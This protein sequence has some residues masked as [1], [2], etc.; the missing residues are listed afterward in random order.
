MLQQF[1]V[2]DEDV[3]PLAE[4]VLEVLEKV[5]ILCQNDEL[6]GL[7]DRAGATV[8]FAAQRAR[9]P[10]QMVA[11]Y[12]AQFRSERHDE[13]PCEPFRAPGKPVLGPQAAQFY[14]DPVTGERRSGNT[15]DF[16]ECLKLGE[17]LHGDQ[18]VGHALFST[19][20]PPLLEPLNAAI[21]LA[22]HATRINWVY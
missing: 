21:L 1:L 9:F 2:R 17:M 20:V 16:I 11:E 18:G 5:G 22:E 10:K 8:D 4:A 7:L 13:L 14:L 19:D 6:L 15:R 12:V 3:E